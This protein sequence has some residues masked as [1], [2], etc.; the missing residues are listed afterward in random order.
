MSCCV[1]QARIYIGK[2]KKIKARS[3]MKRNWIEWI[4][5]CCAGAKLYIL[6]WETNKKFYD[7]QNCRNNAKLTLNCPLISQNCDFF[8][9]LYHDETLWIDITNSFT[10]KFSSSSSFPWTTLI[11]L[12]INHTQ[13]RVTIEEINM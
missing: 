11:S 12:L 10:I 5:F 3:R 9:Q 2:R 13:G 1:A 8:F 4:R 6:L 7:S